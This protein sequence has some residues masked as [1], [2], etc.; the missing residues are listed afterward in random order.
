M[1]K[2]IKLLPPLKNYEM[3]NNDETMNNDENEQ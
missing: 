1:S 2:N 3:M